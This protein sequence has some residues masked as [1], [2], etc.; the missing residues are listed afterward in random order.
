MAAERGSIA[1]LAERYRAAGVQPRNFLRPCLL[2]L[3]RERADHGY[4]L[5]ERLRAFGFERDD[6]GAVYRTLRTLERSGA[7]RSSWTLATPGPA[8]RVYELTHEGEMLLERWVRSLA[9]VQEVID[10][11][12]A[13]YARQRAR[14]AALP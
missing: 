2:L 6:P 8:R 12:L 10:R 14:G 3:L 5:I 9:E 4:D 11:F 7:V 13:R 1:P